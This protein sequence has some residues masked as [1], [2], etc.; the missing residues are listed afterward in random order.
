M[1]LAI[2]VPCTTTLIF[3]FWWSMMAGPLVDLVKFTRI[4]ICDVYS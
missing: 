3:G 2:L 1:H 4:V